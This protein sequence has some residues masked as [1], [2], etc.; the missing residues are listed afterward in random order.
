M[1]AINPLVHSIMLLQSDYKI[2]EIMEDDLYWDAYEQL[3]IEL[4]REPIHEEVLEYWEKKYTFT[5][6]ELQAAEQKLE[7][8]K[9][10]W[11]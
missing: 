8:R 7:D 3:E 1:L 9:N 5:K 2:K 6:E 4:G 10:R 11:K